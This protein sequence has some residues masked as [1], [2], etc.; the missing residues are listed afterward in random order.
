MAEDSIGALWKKT[1]QKGEY[2]TGEVEV[3]GVKQRI[4]VF[5]NSYK[6]K[7]NQPD[8]RILASKPQG[9]KP[10]EAKPKSDDFDDDLPF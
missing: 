1:G 3:N 5:K 10:Q 7:E 8:Y 2:M 6:E 4:V 9:D